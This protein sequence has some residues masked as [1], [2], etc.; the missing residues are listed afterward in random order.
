MSAAKGLC[1]AGAVGMIALSRLELVAAAAAGKGIALLD[2][3]RGEFYC[4]VYRD[5]FRI[6]EDL[7]KADAVPALR[8]EGVLLTCEAR[9]AESLGSGVLLVAEPGPSAILA[10][11]LGRIEAGDWSDAAAADANYLRR[12]DAELLVKGR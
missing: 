11:A 7:I 1:E 4:G 3:G 8:N 2:A 10:L 5:G 9:V 6:G 12:T